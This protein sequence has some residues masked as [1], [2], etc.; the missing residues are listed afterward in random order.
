MPRTYASTDGTNQFAEQPQLRRYRGGAWYRVRR[1]RGPHPVVDAFLDAATIPTGFDSMEIEEGIDGYDMVT[2]E[3]AVTGAT[4]DLLTT[5]A[6]PIKRT[7]ERLWNRNEESV[8]SHPGVQAVFAQLNAEGRWTD[9]ATIRQQIEEG[10]ENFTP[11]QDLVLEADSYSPG[12][13]AS[14]PNFPNFGF[15]VD[16]ALGGHIRHLYTKLL[17]GIESFRSSQAVLR[18]TETIFQSS[19]LRVQDQN[20]DRILTYQQLASSEPTL[21]AA[22]LI[23]SANLQDYQWY[24]YPPEVR[25][26]SR[27]EWQMIQEYESIFSF[28]SWLYREAI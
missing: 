5:Q 24:K 12:L 9:I 14:N 18:K 21:P 16:P 15:T 22:A 13:L 7:W 20:N 26:V 8:W 17:S 1:W 27:N 2:A 6:D 4:G 23:D 11:P 3:Y 25:Q 19:A 28:D 10:L